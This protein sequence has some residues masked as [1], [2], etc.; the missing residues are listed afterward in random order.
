METE[1][2]IN[3]VRSDKLM[4]FYKSKAWLTLRQEALKR[5]HYECQSCKRKGKYRR[6]KNVHHI[7]EVKKHP[8][9]A[10]DL[11]NLESICIPCH[12]DEHKRLEKYQENKPKFVNEE[13]W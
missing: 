13:R 11:D 12:N 8:E 2:I 7:K 10:L 9:L 6:A 4:K 1:E 5:D 3:L